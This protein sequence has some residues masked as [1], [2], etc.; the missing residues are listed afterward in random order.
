MSIKTSIQN[1]SGGLPLLIIEQK[2]RELLQH[3]YDNAINWSEG[4]ELIN[5][6]LYLQEHDGKRLSQQTAP[7]I[8]DWIKSVYN[9]T[10]FK[11]FS[12]S[13]EE[14]E[15]EKVV[16]VKTLKTTLDTLM[17]LQPITAIRSF[18]EEKKGD[19][20][21]DF[22]NFQLEEA[23]DMLEHER[24]NLNN[25][26]EK[27][28]IDQVL[29]RS[30]DFFLE[31]YKEGIDETLFCGLR[32][33]IVAHKSCYSIAFC[34]AT[35]QYVAPLKRTVLVGNGALLLS[36][37][38]DFIAIAG[39]APRDWIEWFELEENHLELYWTLE[40][41]YTREKLS[42]LKTLFNKTTPALLALVKEKIISLEKE[43]WQLEKIKTDLEQL[44]IACCLQKRTR[45]KK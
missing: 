29:Q 24:V 23:L 44:G 28:T 16:L 34:L 43:L 41:A 2:M 19:A 17:H 4:I 18:L 5:D 1:L 13:Y 40:I 3:L 12:G 42:A 7:L 8:L 25:S 6:L 36:Q 11:G 33:T 20:L 31:R 27:H 22:E 37:K 45:R 26:I 30:N 32:R 38:S 9:H 35:E 39:S 15:I 21:G 14:G 10:L